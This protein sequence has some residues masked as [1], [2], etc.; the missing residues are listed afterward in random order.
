MAVSRQPTPHVCPGHEFAGTARI[1]TN[2]KKERVKKN[3]S[4]TE[5]L[6]IE[7]NRAKSTRRPRVAA[8]RGN[9]KRIAFIL[10]NFFFL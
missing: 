4:R 8:Q 6:L 10:L 5:E 3:N 1:N 7:A 2:A 9:G